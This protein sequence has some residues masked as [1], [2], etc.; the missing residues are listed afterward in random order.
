M[1]Q[2]ELE[3]THRYN[4]HDHE[5]DNSDDD[6]EEVPQHEGGP[7][8]WMLLCR[9][10]QH[11]DD[12]LS[13]GTQSHENMQFD[14]TET[15]R[16]MPAALLRESANWITKRRDEALEDP[17]RRQQE[18]VDPARLNRQQMLAYN[19]LASHHA[20][21]NSATPPEPLQVIIT[22]TAGSGKSYLINA[23]KALLGATCILTGTTGLAGYNIEGCTLHSALQLPVRNNNN[24]D[25]Q[26][27]ALQRLQL[28]FSGKQYLIT[29][30]MSMLGQR[31]LAWVNKRLRQAT[32]KLNEPLGGIS[33]MLLGDFAQLLPVGDKP[34]YASPSQSSFLL[35]QH[36]HSIYCLF[37]TV[38]MLS[39]NIRQAGN[40]P[41]A[42]EFR[43][44]LLR[45]RDGQ[46]TQDD[47]TTLCQR[48][49][50]HANMSDFTDAPRLYFDKLSVEKYNFEKLKN[51]GLQIARISAIHSGRNAKNAK[52]NDAGGLDAVIFL[53]RG[54]AVM[55][56]SNLWQEVGLCNGAT[57]VVED[58]LFHPDR[59]P[60][61]LPIAALV[62]FSHY[63]GP[64]FLPTNPKTVPILPHLFEWESDG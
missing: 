23:I 56:T 26:G 37:Q 29:D 46:S 60:P 1:L 53:A 51:L 2:Q 28:G 42:E 4:G 25:L 21:L 62:H 20:A 22:G 59:S 3:Q 36:G 14:W 64:A 38:V 6:D 33:V 11:Y 30:K 24:N 27:T 39:E 44:I 63:T 47:W 19:I 31:T 17:I 52:S 40:N 32:G 5:E 13:Q 45:L 15:A 43:A 61:C 12:T 55:L 57:G 18:T 10:N 41:E 48:T 7:E 9:L 8:E 54:A 16:A 34:I 50:Q 58:L 35:T 49:P